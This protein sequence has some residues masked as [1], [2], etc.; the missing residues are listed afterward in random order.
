MFRKRGNEAQAEGGSTVKVKKQRKPMGKKKKRIIIAAVIVFVVALIIVIPKVLGGGEAPAP[1]VT[2]GAVEKMDI[3]EAVSIKGTIEGSQKA[4]V[5][6][7][8]N[9]KILSIL[10]HEGDVVKKIKY[11]QFLIRRICRTIIKKQ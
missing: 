1:A 10:V 5:A 2:T 6:S 3:E 4:D 7:S 11:L 9:Y 8:V